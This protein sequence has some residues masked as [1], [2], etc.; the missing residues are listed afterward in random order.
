[1]H[2]FY[3]PRLKDKILELTDDEFHHCVQVLRHKVGDDIH[4]TNGKGLLCQAKIT[5]LSKKSVTFEMLE[6]MEIPA[7]GYAVHLAIAPTKQMERIEWLV[8]KAC[9][10]GVDSI[11]FLQTAN[12]ERP[13]IKT[14]RLEKKAISALKQSKGAWITLIQPMGKFSDY[15][16][17]KRAGTQ[18]LAVVSNE[19]PLL[20][21]LLE[22]GNPVHILIG[23]EGD[24]NLQEVE[25]A[26]Q[27]G[28]QPVSLGSRVLRT[29]TA[30]LLACHSVVLV[31]E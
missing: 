25:A 11:T 1:M 22:R 2:L 26:V 7:K 14:D 30:G 4:V 8:E 6:T 13:L 12:S 3:Q 27:A 10:I 29:E 5:G 19:N 18:C 23:P 15:L 24:F 28:F 31:N 20:Y 17:E 16:K 21:G 9:E